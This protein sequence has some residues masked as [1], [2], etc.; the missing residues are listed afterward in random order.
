[1]LLNIAAICLDKQQ[2]NNFG[3][4]IDLAH[5]KHSFNQKSK[6]AAVNG[7]TLRTSKLFPG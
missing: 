2:S 1:M 3:L 5:K 6:I 7:K 4:W